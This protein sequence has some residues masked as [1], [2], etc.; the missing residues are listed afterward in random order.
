MS[1]AAET[2]VAVLRTRLFA[3][4]GEPPEALRNLPERFQINE[5]AIDEDVEAMSD[6]DWDRALQ[7]VLA[8]DRCITV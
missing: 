2:S 4:G 1:E 5:I 8:S 7:V 3:G 6:A